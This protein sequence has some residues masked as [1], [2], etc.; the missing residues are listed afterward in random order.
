MQ[1]T[2]ALVFHLVAPVQ[3]LVLQMTHRAANMMTVPH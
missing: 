3:A 1:R 2:P